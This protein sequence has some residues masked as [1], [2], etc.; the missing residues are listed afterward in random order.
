MH[1]I[2]IR[3]IQSSTPLYEVLRQLKKNRAATSSLVIILFL[4]F[5]AMIGPFIAPHDPLEQNLE[6]R[7]LA[8]NG[9]YLLGTDD[10]GRCILSRIIY[11]T[12]I[13]LQIG[14]IVVGIAAAIGITLGAVAGYYGGIVDEIIMRMVDIMLSFPG[15]ILALAIAGAFGP[16][17]FNV[18]LALAFVHW[19]G[20]ARLMRGSVLSVKEKGFIEAAH[21]IGASSVR[22]MFHH[23]LPN[24]MAPV[25]VMAT[26]GMACVILAAAALSFLGLGAQP[27]TPEWG[28]MLNRGRAFM[29]TAPHLM[30]FPGL[31]IMV[32]V[33]AF[34]LLGDGLRDVLDPRL[35]GMIK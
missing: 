6:K 16:S 33:L 13:S 21:A 30:I 28:A 31:M 29:R 8:P 15:I 2:G 17:L 1:D 35:K 3:I 9:E 5:I 19:T 12:R 25:I 22:I 32:T 20:Y 24:C 11:G 4:L 23:I 34:N 10:L 27:P 14:I 18:M 26:L 7:L